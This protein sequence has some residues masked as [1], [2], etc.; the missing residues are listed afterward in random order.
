MLIAG[1][2]ECES[3]A[4]AAIFLRL[5]GSCRPFVQFPRSYDLSPFFNFLVYALFFTWFSSLFPPL[6]F[7]VFTIFL[8]RWNMADA[9]LVQ[10]LQSSKYKESTGKKVEDDFRIP[11][12]SFRILFFKPCVAELDR[13]F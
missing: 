6:P 10:G 4:A 2:R 3:R 9:R 5:S 11:P 8:R 13:T 12:P 1:A 7:A